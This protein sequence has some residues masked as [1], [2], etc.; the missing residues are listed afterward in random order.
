MST[1]NIIA[2]DKASELPYY[3][4]PQYPDEYTAGTVAARMIDGLGFRYRWATENL[5]EEDL[6]YKPSDNAR[7]TLETIDHLLGLSHVI[8]N[9]TLKIPTDVTKEKTALSYLEK[10]KKTL[11]NFKKASDILMKSMNVEGFKIQFISASGKSE[12]PFWNN[13]NGPIAD[14]IWHSGQIA[15]FRRSSGNPIS[16]KVKFLEGKIKE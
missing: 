12:Y 1:I 14:A 8:V 6:H 3:E 10:R 5:R 4:V 9:A 13:I 2:Q 15:S 11:Y 16:S 7:T